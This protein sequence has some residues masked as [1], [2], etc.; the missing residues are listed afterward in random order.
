[1]N[2]KIYPI[3]SE[4]APITLQELKELKKK[5]IDEYYFQRSLY[6]SWLENQRREGRKKYKKDIKDT[7]KSLRAM[8]K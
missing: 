4:I 8:P 5:D 7:I 6:H 2:K 3:D 1:M